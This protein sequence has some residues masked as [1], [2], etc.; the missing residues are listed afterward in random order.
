[1]FENIK[2]D[3]L[4]NIALACV[5]FNQALTSGDPRIQ[6]VKIALKTLEKTIPLLG[7]TKKALGAAD[8]LSHTIAH[9][10][11]VVYGLDIQPNNEQDAKILIEILKQVKCILMLILNKPEDYLPLL[12]RGALSTEKG[13]N[14]FEKNIK[15]IELLGEVLSARFELTSHLKSDKA[16]AI[17]DCI[18]ICTLIS[19]QEELYKKKSCRDNDTAP[20]LIHVNQIHALIVKP[21][22]THVIKHHYDQHHPLVHNAQTYIELINP[23]HKMLLANA[24]KYRHEEEYGAMVESIDHYEKWFTGIGLPLD[25]KQHIL[26]PDLSQ[27]STVINQV[28]RIDNNKKDTPPASDNDD[29]DI[30]IDATQFIPYESDDESSSKP[31][32]IRLEKDEFLDD[33]NQQLAELTQQNSPIS[34]IV[35]D[36]SSSSSTHRSPIKRREDT[37]GFGNFSSHHNDM[38]TKQMRELDVDVISLINQGASTHHSPVKKVDKGTIDDDAIEYLPT[39]FDETSNPK[40]EPVSNRIASI[41]P[42]IN[43]PPEYPPYTPKEIALSMLYIGVV[44]LIVGAAATTGIGAFFAL[45]SLT[46]LFTT[47][48]GIAMLTVV[49]A[50]VLTYFG[51]KYK[52]GENLIERSSNLPK[53]TRDSN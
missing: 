2:T 11:Y 8:T 13:R 28:E 46:A 6:K 32:S 34:I 17:E 36:A 47:T 29:D 31:I 52:R 49:A 26:M 1:M 44:G 19:I 27:K 15:R 53:L 48:P 3:N 38:P 10:E 40:N 35:S 41:M 25:E 12:V 33:W 7:E 39:L 42:T 51:V 14:A 37:S 43:P 50:P 30:Q 21:L 5:A 18:D 9:L 23:A 20:Y 24:K 22:I 4:D 45:S 16:F